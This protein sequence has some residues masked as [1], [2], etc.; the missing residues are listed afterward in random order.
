MENNSDYCRHSHSLTFV[1]SAD[2]YGLQMDNDLPK[3]AHN[4]FPN[5]GVAHQDR[6][7]VFLATFYQVNVQ[8]RQPHAPLQMQLAQYLKNNYVDFDLNLKNQR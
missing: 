1:H 4:W 2:N 7:R 8:F 6:T 5:D 3:F